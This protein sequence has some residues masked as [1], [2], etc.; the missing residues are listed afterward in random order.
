MRLAKRHYRTAVPVLGLLL[1]AAG[2]LALL[3]PSTAHGCESCNYVFEE[4]LLAERRDTPLGRDALQA[5]ENQRDLPLRGLA[6]RP[7]PGSPGRLPGQRATPA[8]AQQETTPAQPPAVAPPAATTPRDASRGNPIGSPPADR[9]FAEIF[10]GHEFIEIIERDYALP[11]PPTGYVPQDATPDKSFTITLHEGQTY[12][13]NNVMYDGFLTDGKIPGPTI[14]VDEGDIV[15]FTVVND[16]TVPHGA[17]LHAA[18]TQ[19]SA[20]LG[21]I[22]P[23]ESRSVLFRATIPGVYMYH[24]AP[25]GHAIPM[26]VLFG[27][28]GMMVVR[29][30]TRQFELERLL[31]H[32]PDVE[33]F[34]IQHE[35]YASGKDA[36]EGNPLYVLFNGKTFRYVEEPIQARPGDYVRVNFLN[37]GP[38]LLST[39]HLVGIIWDYAYWQGHPEA[40]WPGGQSVTAGPTDSWVVEFR[41]PPDEGPYT[42]VTHAVGSTSRGAIGLLVGDRAAVTPLS[43]PAD[44]PSY[45]EAELQSLADGV[46]RVIS[47]FKPGTPDV[48]PPVVFGAETEEVTVRIIGNSYYPKI[49]QVTPGT[50]VTWVNEDVFSY[51]AGEVSGV[52]NAVS[53]S[54][55]ERFASPLLAHTESYSFTF[56]ETG[57]YEYICTPHP[58][59]MGKIV[60]AREGGLPTMPISLVAI[61]LGATALVVAML[62]RQQV[63]T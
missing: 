38:N 21:N 58:Y 31:G 10:E 60:V 19:T 62:T 57:E 54:G 23:G 8:R 47:P 1:T 12:I 42:I 33:I 14:V 52:H 50:T 18:Y 39:F 24:C 5:M 2:G 16:G 26:H 9:N 20:Y 17:S 35:L 48:D 25:G 32:P 63:I 3:V 56:T 13:G 6:A 34:L 40:R 46:T 11:I 28:Y 4:E 44:G 22:P 59:M 30:T 37:I 55:P 15:E 53:T 27:Q 61:V 49:L 43:I 7:A 36:I 41:M 29:P 51:L 45:G